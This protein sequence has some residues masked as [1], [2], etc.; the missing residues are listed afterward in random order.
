[1]PGKAEELLI[2]QPDGRFLIRPTTKPG[3]IATL[4]V[5]LH[6]GCRHLNVRRRA[7]GRVALGM[8]KDDERAFD[9]LEA[10]VEYHREI[11]LVV[12]GVGDTR[13]TGTV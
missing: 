8:M 12:L 9:S 5:A 11:P 2:D 10:L 4:S 13:L 3:A 7:D 1:M 6:F